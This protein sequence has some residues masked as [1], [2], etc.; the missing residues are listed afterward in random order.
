MRPTHQASYEIKEKN[1][2]RRFSLTRYGNNSDLCDITN[3]YYVLALSLIDLDGKESVTTINMPRE[4]F[5]FFRICMIDSD[6][7]LV[8]I[9]SDATP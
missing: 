1:V 8:E 9:N 4:D 3:E 7:D 5:H 2:T 6:F